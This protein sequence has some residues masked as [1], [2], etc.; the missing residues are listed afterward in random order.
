MFRVKNSVF[1]EQ[2]RTAVRED[3][4]TQDILKEINLRDIKGFTKKERFLLFQKKIYVP[5]KIRKEI[6]AK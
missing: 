1:A 2:L 5:T 6:I 3:K 4:T